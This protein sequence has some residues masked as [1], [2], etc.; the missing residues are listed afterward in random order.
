MDNK[1]TKSDSPVS[2]S[3]HSPIS[4]V[5]LGDFVEKEGVLTFNGNVDEAG[6]VFVDFVC[7]SFNQR[8]K[9]STEKQLVA[10]GEYLLSDLRKSRYTE[11]AHMSSDE[12]GLVDGFTVQERLST[13]NDVDIDY[14]FNG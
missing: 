7:A 11:D 10:F 5:W 12:T 3:I 8:M 9:E 13:V 6:R 14:F 1:I 4:G 2:I